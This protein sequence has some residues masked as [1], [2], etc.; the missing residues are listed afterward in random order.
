MRFTLPSRL[1]EVFALVMLAG[2]LSTAPG[3]T[4]E[5]EATAPDLSGVVKGID[6]RVVTNASIFI[7]TAGPRVGAGYT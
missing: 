6:G 1:A 4:G 3:F 7:Y 5:T 2:F